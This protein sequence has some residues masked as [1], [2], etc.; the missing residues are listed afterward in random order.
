VG[1]AVAPNSDELRDRGRLSQNG[2]KIRSTK[3][4][5]LVCDRLRPARSSMS[6]YVERRIQRYRLCHGSTNDQVAPGA[7]A[8]AFHAPAARGPHVVRERARPLSQ[9]VW[10]P[11]MSTSNGVEG[12]GLP[13]LDMPP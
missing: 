5:I 7:C 4:A 1:A 13:R 11:S 3:F 12:D 10:A 2:R 8:C 6:I 9:V